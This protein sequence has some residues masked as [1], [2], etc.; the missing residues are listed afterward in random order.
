MISLENKFI[1][2]CIS[3]LKSDGISFSL[4]EEETTIY[5]FYGESIGK[6]KLE[7]VV[8]TKGDIILKVSNTIFFRRCGIS[9][10]LESRSNKKGEENFAKLH[11]IIDS[12]FYEMQ[13]QIIEYVLNF[14]EKDDK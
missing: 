11:P 8:F 5:D 1:Q 4:D 9:T 14:K 3:D 7:N 10:I 13:R 2:K 12:E 6:R